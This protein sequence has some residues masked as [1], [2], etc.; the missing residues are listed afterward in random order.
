MKKIFLFSFLFLFLLLPCSSEYKIAKGADVNEFKYACISNSST[1]NNDNLLIFES[2]LKIVLELCGL[3]ILSENE[4]AN[5]SE[6]ERRKC[7]LVKYGVDSGSLTAVSCYANCIFYNY[8]TN[9]VVVKFDASSIAWVS[10]D[11]AVRAAI[12][13]VIKDIK[14]ILY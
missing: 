8:F 13:Y 14:T 10:N 1:L 12:D 6:F 4:V 11:N 7:F 3:K 2:K 5:L 9:S